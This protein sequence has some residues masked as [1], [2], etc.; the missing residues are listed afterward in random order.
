MADG[1]DG[2]DAGDEFA[3]LA[4]VP[5]RHLRSGLEVCAARGRVGLP[6]T[7]RGDLD[8]A[9]PGEAVYLY[10]YQVGERPLPAATW[11]ARFVAAVD[12]VDGDHPDPDLSPPT[13][14]EERT[15]PA[16]IAGTPG[17]GEAGTID[18]NAG[19]DDPDPDPDEDLA[20]VGPPEVFLEVEELQ[21]LDKRDWLFTNELVPK[22]ERGARAFVPITPV[23][24]RLPE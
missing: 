11:R 10:A 24:V 6:A 17:S 15:T 9:S 23:R 1:S 16:P 3:L 22:Q 20:G 18:R 14:R 19:A 13:W 5:L 4:A 12:A 8:D 2:L 21:E 7:G